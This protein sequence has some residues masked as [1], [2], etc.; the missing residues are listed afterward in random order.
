M[1]KL[2]IWMTREKLFDLPKKIFASAI[3]V[4]LVKKEKPGYKPGHSGFAWKLRMDY[5]SYFIN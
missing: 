3:T 1:S 5:G 4:Y 2:Q